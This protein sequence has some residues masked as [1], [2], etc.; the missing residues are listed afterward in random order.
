MITL[1]CSLHSGTSSWLLPDL[2]GWP[3]AICLN[4]NA[5]QSTHGP[6]CGADAGREG[7][8]GP[9]ARAHSPPAP[10]DPGRAHSA[11]Q[12]QG[13]T[14]TAICSDWPV[15]PLGSPWGPSKRRAQRVIKPPGAAHP[16]RPR[17][18]FSQDS[19]S[20]PLSSF[21]FS[22]IV[23]QED[24]IF[25]SISCNSVHCGFLLHLHRQPLY[26]PFRSNPQRPSS[27]RCPRNPDRPQCCS[28]QASDISR[29]SLPPIAATT[30]SS[31]SS[32]LFDRHRYLGIL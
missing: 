28:R 6:A 12:L 7:S 14:F 27:R 24:P 21:P 30:L 32:C 13:P 17:D 1:F 31:S 19:S 26:F 11:E 10:P 9:K 23:S 8:E 29:R 4:K 5:M 16:P 22:W 3:V 18:P 15:P 2:E 25:P 20:F